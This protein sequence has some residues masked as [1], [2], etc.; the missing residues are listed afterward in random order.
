MKLLLF[1]VTHV[2]T[3]EFAS[4]FTNYLGVVR[5]QLQP[6]PS[7]ST[8]LLVD[9]CDHGANFVY[10]LSM[11]SLPSILTSF[12]VARRF[13]LKTPLYFLAAKPKSSFF[14]P[15]SPVLSRMLLLFYPFKV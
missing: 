10:R 5:L 1:A 4:P 13:T 15:P 8:L 6:V 11:V 7:N 9:M 2:C 12:V 14:G 3:H